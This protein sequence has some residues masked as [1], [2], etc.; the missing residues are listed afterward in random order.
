MKK[1][2]YILL[3]TFSQFLQAQ[4]ITPDL[5]SIGFIVWDNTQYAGTGF[6]LDTKRQVVTCAHV[7]D[8]NHL[9]YY[10]SI[11]VNNSPG[12]SHKLKLVKLLPHYDLAILESEEDL[13]T[14]PLVCEKYFA[15]FPNQHLFYY[16]YNAIR[17]NDMVKTIQANNA[18]LSSFG[19]TFEG[20]TVVDFIEFN[21]LGLPGYSGGPVLNEK[22]KVVAILREAWLKQGLKG[23][24]IQLINRAYSIIPI[25]N[26]K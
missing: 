7:I 13:C 22:G 19:K 6:V 11:S 2:I 14:Q 17:S 12:I 8:T 5:A 3:L 18:Y 24:Q 25:C 9:I 4:S 26:S 15:F 23:G 10:S 16:G 21:G 20:N 1:I